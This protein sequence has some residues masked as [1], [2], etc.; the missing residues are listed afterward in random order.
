MKNS[1]K[2]IAMLTVIALLTGL[3]GMALADDKIYT[4]GTFKIPRNR[5]VIIS[6]DIA[7]QQPAAESE[8]TE[9]ELPLELPTGEPAEDISELPLELP[10]EQPAE[11]VSQQP[12]NVPEEQPGEQT[13]EQPAEDVSEQPLNVPEE[14]TTEQ[15]SEQP[16]EQPAEQT[17]EQPAEQPAEQTTEQPAEEQKAEQPAEQPKPAEKKPVERQ[18]RIY[19]SRKD[20]VIENEIIELT[21]E[22]I[23]F[24]DVEVQYQWQVDRGDGK[25][26]VDV[27]GANRSK[28]SFVARKDTI[29]YNWRL[30]I[31]VDE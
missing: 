3:V 29:L 8:L 20:V 11:D 1:K 26:W 4:S 15:P 10:G 31:T 9:A 19:S 17:G 2:L 23:G 30:V 16:A 5:V 28:H 18:V 27:E 12:L 25:G 22:L 24:D 6:E 7:G 14:Q 21:S 13:T